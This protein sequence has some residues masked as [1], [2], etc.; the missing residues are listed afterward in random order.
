M[1]LE[2][3]PLSARPDLRR[4]VF[5]EALQSLWPEYMM[6]DPAGDLHFE[7]SQFDRYQ[8]CSFAILDPAVPEAPVGRAFSVPFAFD[9]ERTE[10]PDSGW[11]G[12]IRW[13]QRDTLAGR[14]ANA[15]SAL[16]ITL[17]PAYRG[18]GASAVILDAMRR[19]AHALGYRRLFAPVRPTA[20]HRE[21]FLPMADYLRRR[22]PDG[23]S[24]DPWIRTHERAG[25]RIIKIAPTS[26]V[27]PGTL[28]EWRGWTGLPL[29]QSGAVAIPGGLAPLLVSVEQDSAVYVEPNI[30]IEHSVLP[31][32]ASPGD[33]P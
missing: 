29:A 13:G 7:D 20:K 6:H 10:L 22:G 12:V 26:M 11:D 14:A 16:E 1:K 8:D 33:A 23:L 5:A 4:L 25:G 2:L 9:G 19:R 27:I 32:P 31:G 18:R 30:W 15:L 17:L 21:P 3:V 28:A 24:V